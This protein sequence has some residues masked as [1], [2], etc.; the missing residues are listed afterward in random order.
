MTSEVFYIIDT[1]RLSNHE[2]PLLSFH[3]DRT[4]EA[5]RFFHPDLKKN[6]IIK[7]YLP[8]QMTKSK[9]DQKC[10]F[11][12]DPQNVQLV[13]TEITSLDSLPDKIKLELATHRNQ[14][15]GTGLQNFKTS[16]R[17][18][19]DDNMS[20]RWPGADDVVGINQLGQVTETSRFNLFIQTQHKFYTPSLNSGCV[21]GCLRR[22][23]LNQ[24][25][26]EINQIK[27]SLEEKDFFV[28]ELKNVEIFVGN[29]LRGITKAHLDME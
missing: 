17:Q 27:Y 19:W 18:Y 16:H 6:E 12:I 13:Q 7:M 28:D 24:G 2:N 21:N 10:R 26:I 14:K 8:F 23:Y 15:D 9:E 3:I 25:F 20:L 5:V 22:F 29:S 11:M 1:F 4:F